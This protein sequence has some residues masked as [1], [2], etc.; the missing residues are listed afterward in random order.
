MKR[1]L[2]WLLDR[3]GIVSSD[4][5]VNERLARIDRELDRRRW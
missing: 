1:F 5:E 3:L 4:P 2:I